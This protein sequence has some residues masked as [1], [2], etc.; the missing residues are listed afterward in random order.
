VTSSREN[1]AGDTKL[2]AVEVNRCD[3]AQEARCEVMSTDDS[4]SARRTTSA[5]NV[6]FV[7]TPRGEHECDLNE[8]EREVVDHVKRVNNTDNNKQLSSK[9]INTF[10][11]CIEKSDTLIDDVV[12]FSANSAN[13]K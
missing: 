10:V 8:V 6:A 3:T 7:L 2:I 12:S 4:A 5:P 11:S 9:D 1:L 13:R